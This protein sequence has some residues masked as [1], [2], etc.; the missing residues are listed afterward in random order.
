MG[1]IRRSDVVFLE[2]VHVERAHTVA[3]T[4]G[5]GLEG[6]RDLGLL[7]SAVMAPQMGYYGTLA[8]LAAV[9]A[10]GIAKNHAFLDANKRTGLL[11]AITFL[12]AN[13][14][15]LTLIG[16]RSKLHTWASWADLME[17]V[18]AGAVSR[19]ELVE[20]FV[21]EMGEAVEIEPG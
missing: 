14:Y 12:E 2:R 13:G 8:E 16:A 11:A 10:H 5:G 4:L 20:A 17:F 3:L 6:I 9:Y 18:A 15:V 7:E 1:S 19:D 21:C